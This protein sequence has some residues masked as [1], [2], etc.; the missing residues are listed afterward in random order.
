M[1]PT[2][3]NWSRNLSLDLS[4]HRS[5]HVSVEDQFKLLLLFIES[6]SILIEETRIKGVRTVN[7]IKRANPNSGA[8]KGFGSGASPG[9]GYGK[10]SGNKVNNVFDPTLFPDDPISENK[11]TVFNINSERGKKR[12]TAPC[13]MMCENSKTWEGYK[14]KEGLPGP[15]SMFFC[16][17]MNNASAKKRA[18]IVTDYVLCGRCLQ[19]GDPA[20]GGHL[21]ADCKSKHRCKSCRED[22]N[23]LLHKAW[24]SPESTAAKN[25]SNN[26]EGATE[27]DMEQDGSGF[28]DELIN[29]VNNIGKDGEDNL[30]HNWCHMVSVS[31]VQ[32]HS[33]VS[34][35]SL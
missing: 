5:N 15:G 14:C 6:A 34:H 35:P 11:D 17:T 23:S 16:E 28:T 18:K 30:D 20:T 13:K 3:L 33:K 31:G 27:E 29:S 8:S 2:P 10:G 9:N 25:S 19:N 12:Q 32:S 7:A 24:G 21:Q 26:I 4:A 22:H 1:T